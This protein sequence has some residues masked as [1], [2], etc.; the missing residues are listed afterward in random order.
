MQNA[1][2]IIDSVTPETFQNQALGQGIL[3]ED[4]EYEGLTTYESF[5]DA[6]FQA[7][8]NRQDLGGIEGEVEINISAEW[9]VR[10]VA[11]QVAVINFVG[12]D[13]IDRWN[14]YI[15]ANLVK[16][17]QQTM[18]RLFPSS[19]VNE[20]SDDVIDLKI[21]SATSVE[22]H[23]KNITWIVTTDYGLLMIALKNAKGRADGSISGA[24]RGEGSIPFRAEGYVSD[25]R[26]IEYVPADI[27]IVKRGGGVISGAVS[28]LKE[29]TVTELPTP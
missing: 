9:R 8:E 2:F 11:E 4:F 1:N 23:K 6:I 22:A 18:Q 27:R 29:P 19:V 7:M 15:T 14:C 12:Q 13:I 28:A 25:L 10:A 16:F 26:D 17:D 21:Q 3:I 5:R 20:I 24:V